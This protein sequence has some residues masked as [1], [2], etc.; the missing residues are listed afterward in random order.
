[1]S[2]R[3]RIA[4]VAAASL[5]VTAVTAPSPGYAAASCQDLHRLTSAEIAAYGKAYGT[6]LSIGDR[7]RTLALAPGGSQAALN[8]CNR[9]YQAAA[10]E[11][12]R[13]HRSAQ[14]LSRTYVAKCGEGSPSAGQMPRVSKAER[15]RA[16]IEFGIGIFG[17]G[18]SGGG[19]GGG[20]RR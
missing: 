2:L 15:N 13:K 12:K 10:A 4:E 18:H 5:L 9:Q 20:H 17:G 1:M 7:C 3:P 6:E 8:Q 16:I 19:M 11:A 14:Q